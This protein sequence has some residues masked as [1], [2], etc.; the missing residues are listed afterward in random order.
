MNK[1]TT[2]TRFMSFSIFYWQEQKNCFEFKITQNATAWPR[3]VWASL[4]LWNY[5]AMKVDETKH[6]HRQVD[7]VDCSAFCWFGT[8]TVLT[9]SNLN[10]KCYWTPGNTVTVC[11]TNQFSTFMWGWGGGGLLNYH[12]SDQVP[13]LANTFFAQH[14]DVQLQGKATMHR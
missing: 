8:F 5:L 12:C 3:C 6:W 11:F 7:K 13:F 9:D 2:Q 4:T 1:Q 14:T 10:W